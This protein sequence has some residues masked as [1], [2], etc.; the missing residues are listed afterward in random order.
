[1]TDT[2]T[3]DNANGMNGNSHRIASPG[4]DCHVRQVIPVPYPATVRNKTTLKVAS[5]N[6][7]TLFQ[8]RTFDNVKQEMTRMRIHILGMCEIRWTGAGLVTSDEYTVIY[9]GGNKHEKGVGILLDE[10]RSKC[11]IGYWTTSDRIMLVKLK[12][13]PFD[14]SIIQVHCICTNCR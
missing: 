4:R 7:R 10:Q 9:S 5:W 8:N 11:L 1:M 13:K 12:G 14:I 6:V 3:N 2:N